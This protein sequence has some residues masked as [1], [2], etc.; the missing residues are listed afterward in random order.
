MC[1]GFFTVNETLNSNMY[2]WFF[3]A[4]VSHCIEH[5]TFDSVVTIALMY[6]GTCDC[7]ICVCYVIIFAN[8]FMLHVVYFRATV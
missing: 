2:F 1:A 8:I 4:K 6:T 7:G 3:P 5:Y